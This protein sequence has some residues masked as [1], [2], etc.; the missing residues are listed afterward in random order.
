MSYGFPAVVAAISTVLVARLA[1]ASVVLIDGGIAF[2]RDRLRE[3][4]APPRVVVVPKGGA[5]GGR[6]AA[7]PSNVAAAKLQRP[8]ASRMA[9]GEVHCWGVSYEQA[10]LLM[11]Q[12]VNSCLDVAVGLSTFTSASWA[13]ET[14]ISQAGQRV[15]FG[16]TVVI[17]IVDGAIPMFLPTPQ[18][19][20]IVQDE[21]HL[22]QMSGS[23]TT[24]C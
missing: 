23:D 10:E 24:A 17:P 5:F 6:D 21:G 9:S 8:R 3:Q 12:Y 18:N 22:I 11:D 13:E 15:M 16:F 2:G 4:M 19:P 7:G 14:N 20:L 1:T